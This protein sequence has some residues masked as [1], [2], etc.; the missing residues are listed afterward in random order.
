MTCVII[1]A[2]ASGSSVIA[3]PD[4]T[5]GIPG[6]VIIKARV[7]IT[8]AITVIATRAIVTATRITPSARMLICYPIQTIRT[9]ALGGYYL[10]AEKRTGL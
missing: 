1:A 5:D 4:I 2:V 9:S 7:T 10:P 3:P 8:T 6:S